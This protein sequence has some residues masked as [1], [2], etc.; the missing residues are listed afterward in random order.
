MKEQLEFFKENGYLV[1]PDALSPEEVR[2]INAAID[3]DL[4]ENS[5]MWIDRGQTGRTQNAH[6]LLACPEMDVTMRPPTL[7]P[8]MR[9]IMGKDL[10]AEE[11]SVML[12]APNPDGDTE[13][14][15][16]RDASDDSGGDDPPYYTRYLSIVYYLTD[17]DDTTHTFS[18][19]PGT[20]QSAERLPLE[21]YDLSAAQHLVGSAGTAILF[22]AATFHAGNVRRTTSERRTIH[23]YCGRTTDR[24]LSN[25]TIFPRRLWEGKDETTQHYYSRPNP[26]TQ[27][28]INQFE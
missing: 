11:H 6:A 19:L 2:S 1:V 15:W 5:V 23:I 3:R 22:N 9:A 14:R 16:H 4:G 10:C 21:A 8:L 12:R 27:L 28:L 7:L 24:Y 25:H 20:A 13:C 17:V 26:I 18:V